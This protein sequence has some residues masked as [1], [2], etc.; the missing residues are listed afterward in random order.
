MLSR[1]S[2]KDLIIIT[3]LAAIGIAI[4]PIVGP[5]SKM[6]STPLMIPGG[7]LAGGFYMMWLALA[8]LIVRKPG[9]GTIFGILQGIIVL[10]VGLQGNQGALSLL[11]Y[12]LPGVLADL[13]PGLKHKGTKYYAHFLICAVAT[14]TGSVIVAWL[15]LGHPYPLII[16]IAALACVSAALG[17]GVS[18]S[19]YKSLRH[20]R[21]IT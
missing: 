20:H 3:V 11:S 12:S 19:I 13:L 5:L 18:W 15:I 17:A 8:I 16:G 9:T 10:L 4:K 1:F 6:L 7:S 21:I 14:V 2:T